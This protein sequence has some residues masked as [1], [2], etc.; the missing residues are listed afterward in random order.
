MKKL[1][2]SLLFIG[3]ISLIS[4]AEVYEAPEKSRKQ[5]EFT[6][7]ITNDIYRI[8][9][10]DYPLFKSKNNRFYIWKVS[11]RTNKKYKYYVP[12]EIQE[13]IE[14]DKNNKSYFYGKR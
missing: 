14:K 10:K 3:I 13:Q 1:I 8:K 5:T 6:D 9:D 2:L 7:T 4:S 11:N 12:K